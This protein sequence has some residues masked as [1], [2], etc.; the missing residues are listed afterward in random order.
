MLKVFL[1]AILGAVLIG[2]SCFNWDRVSEPGVLTQETCADNPVPGCV[3]PED[4]RDSVTA[5]GDTVSR[6]MF[7]GRPNG[8]PGYFLLTVGLGVLGV[9]SVAGIKTHKQRDRRKTYSA[10][11]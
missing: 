5:S 7:L 10:N 9:A 4:I 3:N 6:R 8:V 1:L 2:M 11:S